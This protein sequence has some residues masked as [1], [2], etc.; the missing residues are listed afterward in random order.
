MH[1][2]PRDY[3]TQVDT[4]SIPPEETRVEQIFSVEFISLYMLK[5]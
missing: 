3:Y 4:A 2:I 5:H 1:Y